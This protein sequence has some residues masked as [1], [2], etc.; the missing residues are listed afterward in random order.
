MRSRRLT[1]AFWDRYCDEGYCILSPDFLSGGRAPNGFDLAALAARP[2]ARH[3]R[4]EHPVSQRAALYRSASGRG[5]SASQPLPLGDIDGGG[6]SLLGVLGGYLDGF[7]A[8]AATARGVVRSL[9]VAVD[10]DDLFAVVEHGRTASRPT[11]S[12]RPVR[13]RLRQT[14][15]DLQLV[16]HGCLFRLPAAAT[17]GGSPCTST[18]AAG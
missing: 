3:G 17:S 7:A 15:A 6:T 12:T 13:V 16:R 2:R 1:W 9:S 5:R 14:P 10:G 4:R 11:S 8:R 18:T